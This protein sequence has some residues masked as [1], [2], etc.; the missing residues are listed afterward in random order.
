VKLASSCSVDPSPAGHLS[1][2][3]L[4]VAFIGHCAQLSGAELA[5]ARLLPALRDVDARVVLAEDGNLVRRL[6]DS[7][8][9]VDVLP[10][11][12]HLRG[13]PR[14]RV[15]WRGV[16]PLVLW[17][18]VSYVMRLARWLRRVDPHLVHTSSLKA[19]LYGGL[20][21]RLARLPLVW[22][23]HDRV[24][25]DYLPGPAVRLVRTASR[26]L[27]HAIIANSHA[28]LAA[29]GPPSLR[30]PHQARA[31]IACPIP[32]SPPRRAHVGLR[33]GMVGRL[34]PWKGQH[35]FLQALPQAFPD[36]NAREDGSWEA[37]IVG[38]PMFG[39]NGYE[40][41]LRRLTEE[42]GLE[43]R[44][45]FLGFREDVEE[46]LAAMDVLVHA[47]VIPEPFGQVVVEGM[48]AGLPVIAADS[49]GPAEVIDHEVTGL[50]FPSG[51]SAA[52]AEALR[53]VASDTELR[54]RLGRA[55]RGAA[56]AFA[57]AL[58][59]SQVGD[60]YRSVLDRRLQGRMAT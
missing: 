23:V 45:R 13:M 42:L 54:A 40:R 30:R 32:P 47:S 44:V 12:E 50:L 7:G 34:T 27:P 38:A 14:Q 53:R 49:G 52:L 36:S 9:T 17:R 39:E 55:A 20:A 56:Q 16:T 3:R 48:A 18:W 6:R 29:L 59:A 24:A 2:V 28:T 5:L 25:P 37:V 43:E 41:E 1:D 22:H 60:V 58:I 51:D 8:V 26:W 11:A 46:E 4:R 15:C 35:V 31:V 10:L 19:H 33:I 57:P 21:A